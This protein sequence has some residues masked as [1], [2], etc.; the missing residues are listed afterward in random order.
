MNMYYKNEMKALV[1]LEI[2]IFNGV[3]EKELRNSPVAEKHVGRDQNVRE[4]SCRRRNVRKY[5]RRKHVGNPGVSLVMWLV[6]A[7]VNRKVAEQMI[8][9]RR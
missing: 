1:G 5:D 6:L 7:E 8:M 9:R 3:K 4:K 2:N